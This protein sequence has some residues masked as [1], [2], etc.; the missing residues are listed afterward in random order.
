MKPLKIQEVLDRSYEV[1]ITAGDIAGSVMLV[2]L[3]VLFLLG[4][5]HGQTASDLNSQF[6]DHPVPQFNVRQQQ[7]KI[8]PER[9]RAVN[10]KFIISHG[11]YLGAAIFD[12][13]VTARGLK[14]GKC[15]EKNFGS[16]RAELY[17]KNLGM[18]AGFTLA[19]YGMRKLKIPVLPYLMAPGY[20]S[21]IHIR[22]GSEWFTMGCL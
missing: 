1:H 2:L 9:E 17:G 19:D 11:I 13:E 5:G 6:P 10:K 7:F 20:G 4:T 15:A 3:I 16:N 21:F 8:S 22:G 18:W 12:S 14:A